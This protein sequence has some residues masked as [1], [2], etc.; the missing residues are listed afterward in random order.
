VKRFP[1]IF[2]RAGWY[3]VERFWIS[4]GA[5]G[6]ITWHTLLVLQA[7]C[8]DVRPQV[9]LLACIAAVGQKPHICRKDLLQEGSKE[10][11]SYRFHGPRGHETHSTHNWLCKTSAWVRGQ[12]NSQIGVV[13]SGFP[14]VTDLLFW[15]RTC[16]LSVSYTDSDSQILPSREKQ[17]T[18]RDHWYTKL[19]LYFLHTQCKFCHVRRS[20]TTLLD[21]YFHPRH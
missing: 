16:T 20:T 10:C 17:Q 7:S 3:V 9:N 6:S 1:S 11:F 5:L 21:L 19:V 8:R 12:K 13:K 4:V 14:F 2:K 18:F 15:I